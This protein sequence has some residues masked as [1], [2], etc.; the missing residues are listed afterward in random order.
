MQPAAVAGF[1]KS[2]RED[3]NLRLPGPEPVR[4]SL[5]CWFFVVLV[6][7]NQV[8]LASFGKNCSLGVAVFNGLLFFE[9]DHL[10]F[11]GISDF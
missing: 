7:L 10:H 9:L 4:S 2:G 8:Q 11:R 1:R 3:L 5:S 6:G